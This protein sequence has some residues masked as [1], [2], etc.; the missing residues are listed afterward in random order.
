MEWIIDTVRCVINNGANKLYTHSNL[1][2]MADI[3]TIKDGQE[4]FTIINNQMYLSMDR[5]ATE[6]D[7]FYAYMGVK[8]LLVR[9][10]QYRTSLVIV[11]YDKGSDSYMHADND[12]TRKMVR[13]NT[14]MYNNLKSLVFRDLYNHFLMADINFDDHDI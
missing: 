11:L 6:D 9:P 14:K 4:V 3:Q 8:H 10:G 2:G 5:Y 1:Y 12:Y 13:F 7:R